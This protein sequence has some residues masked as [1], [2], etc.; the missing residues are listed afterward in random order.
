MFVSLTTTDKNVIK[1]IPN[2]IVAGCGSTVCTP[3]KSETT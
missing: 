3:Y 1:G 2:A